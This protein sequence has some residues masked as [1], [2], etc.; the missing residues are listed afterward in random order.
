MT[1]NIDNTEGVATTPFGKYVWQK[2]SGGQ[3]LRYSSIT[4]R[5]KK[6][7]K[8]KKSSSCKNVPKDLCQRLFTVY[9]L[10]DGKRKL[11]VENYYISTS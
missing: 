7:K 6:R 10:N 2:P 1:F 11:I 8:E 5:L 3:G 4:G 9:A